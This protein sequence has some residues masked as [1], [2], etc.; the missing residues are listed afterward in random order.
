M[1]KNSYTKNH[2]KTALRWPQFM[3][4]VTKEAQTEPQAGLRGRGEAAFLGRVQCC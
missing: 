2:L 3:F 1:L 4:G